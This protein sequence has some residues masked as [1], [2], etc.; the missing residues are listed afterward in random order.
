ME[1]QKK[2]RN[3]E[4]TESI[5][6]SANIG[7]PVNPPEKKAIRERA[8]ILVID[9]EPE[10]RELLCR[11]I[12]RQGH[13]VES[14]DNGVAG[15]ELLNDDVFDLIILD[16]RMPKMDGFEV[17]ERI[18][19][20]ESLREVPV[21]VISALHETE[22]VIRGIRMGAEDYFIKPFN[23]VL[24]QARIDTCLEKRRLRLVNR[25][26][27]L[28]NLKEDAKMVAESPAMQRVLETVKAVSRTPVNVLILGE[29]GTGK[30]LIA[31]MIHMN[32]QRKNREL[33]AV[34]CAAIPDN[35]AESEFFGYEKGAF[36][37]AAVSRGGRFEEADG[38]TLLLDEVADMPLE[39]QPKFLR[40]LQEG[41]GRRLGSSRTVSY[42][43][44]L[45]SAT[46]KD[47]AREVAEGRF[48]Q[49]LYYRIFSVEIHLPPL[50]E[51]REDIV[52]LARLFL[53]KISQR[54][55]RRVPRVAPEV[56]E[57][58]ENY[59]WPGNVRQLQH[60]IERLV[61]LTLEGD[62]GTLAQCSQDLQSWNDTGSKK[63]LVHRQN[64]TLP[65]KISELEISCIEQALG[66]AGGQKTQAA[67][68][69][70]ISRQGL[71]KKIRR[72]NIR[73]PVK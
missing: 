9:D 56:F 53:N 62:T 68:R 69:L 38:G 66:E 15:L 48:R 4:P 14:S 40:A 73:L 37:G 46:N 19:S 45:I 22:S 6:R 16:I 43:L 5:S 24:L 42:D 64:Q 11:Y 49:D 3:S 33:V 72:Y 7:L 36:T 58:F 34:N 31:R 54:F 18:K 29:N 51:R 8:K 67:R 17:L 25:A 21:I 70:G 26:L 39:I 13:S 32:S 27:E 55:S 44:R 30:E 59:P 1:Y 57:L 2:S 71:D 35:L 61:A 52:P 28:R 60:E 47:I 10:N 50:R 41:E 20:S 12:I 65:E 63:V 23:P